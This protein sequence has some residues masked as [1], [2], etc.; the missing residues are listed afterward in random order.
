MHYVKR[1]VCLANS[2]KIGGSCI[3]GRELL[4]K[5]AYGGWIRPV[6]ARPTAEVTF[7]ESKYADNSTPKLLDIIDVTL[8]TSDPRQHQVENH[9]IDSA[10]WEKVGELAWDDVESICERP[11]ALWLNSGRTSKGVFDCISKEE[12]A[13]FSNSLVL[14][15]PQD[16]SLERGS[17]TWDG[18]TTKSYRGNFKYNGTYYSLS[19]T[20]PIATDAYATKDEGLYRLHGVYLCISLTEPWEKDNNRCH[21]LI[22]GIISNSTS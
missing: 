14:I 9:V 12:A 20:D 1:F 17:K 4:G 15:K 10:C 5:D 21:K 7:L 8:L 18:K 6:G 13:K 16:F 22:A 11:R 19:V 3:A 2:F